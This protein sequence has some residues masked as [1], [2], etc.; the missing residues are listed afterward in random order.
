MDGIDFKNL[1]SF[2]QSLVEIAETFSDTAEKHLNACGNKLKKELKQNTPDSGTDHKK[3]LN[4]SWKSET[5]GYSG[6]D[7]EYRLWNKAPHVGLVDRGHMVVTK[8]GKVHGFVQG[9]HFI[10]KTTKE[11]EASGAI[12]KELTKFAKDVQ[13]KLDNAR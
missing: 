6:K 1:D 7:L 2:K 3:K 9:T 12:D 4:K 10:D 5:V 11:F 8:G 13:K